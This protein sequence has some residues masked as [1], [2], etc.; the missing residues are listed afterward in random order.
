MIDWKVLRTVFKKPFKM[1]SAVL[2]STEMVSLADLKIDSCICS[3]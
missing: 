2:T 1:N 3:K